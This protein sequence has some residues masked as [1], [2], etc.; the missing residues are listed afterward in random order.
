MFNSLIPFTD[1]HKKPLTRP[2]PSPSAYTEV[3][4][5]TETHSAHRISET[6]IAPSGPWY[7]PPIATHHTTP[8]TSCRGRLQDAIRAIRTPENHYLINTG[9]RPVSSF[10][11]AGDAVA[12]PPSGRPYTLVHSCHRATYHFPGRWRDRDKERQMERQNPH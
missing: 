7:T 5:G 4:F 1:T 10:T 12:N 8:F 9:Y 2:S 3:Q 6:S 11:P